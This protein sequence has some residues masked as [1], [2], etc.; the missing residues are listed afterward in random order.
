[1]INNAMAALTREVEGQPNTLIICMWPMSQAYIG[2]DLQNALHEELLNRGIEHL[3]T[4]TM[5]TQ[6]LVDKMTLD[7][8]IQQNQSVTL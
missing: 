3:P 2:Y 5:V 1:M 8:K 7:S 4:M 6:V